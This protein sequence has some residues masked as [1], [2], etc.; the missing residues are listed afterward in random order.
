MVANFADDPYLAILRELVNEGVPKGDRTK[1][2]MRE[3]FGSPQM[4]FDL[5]TGRFPLLTTKKMFLKGIIHELLWFLKGDTNIKYL[6][7]HGVHIWDAWSGPRGNLGPV[8]GAQWRRWEHIS[9]EP[10]RHFVPPEFSTTFGKVAGVGVEG[11]GRKANPELY[12]TWAG[13]LYRCYDEKRPEYA[14]YGAQGVHVHERWHNFCNFVEDA[15]KLEGWLLKKTFWDKYS[16]DKDRK[17]SNRYGPD[18]CVWASVEEQRINT[19]RAQAVRCLTPEGDSHITMNLAGFCQDMGL[20]RS[21][22]TK[23]LKHSRGSHKGWHFEV[24]TPQNQELAP[25]VRLVDQIAELISLIQH[26][27]E[28]RRQVVSAWNPVEVPLQALPPCH[29]LWQTAVSPL[30]FERRVVWAKSLGFT[31]PQARYANREEKDRTLTAL[32]DHEG[33]PTHEL[34]LKLYQ[35]SADWFLGVPF[36]IA[37]YALLTMMIA[38]VCGLAP[39]KFIHTFGSAHLYENHIEQAKTQLARTPFEAPRMKIRGEGSSLEIDGFKFEDFEL[40]DYEHHP[41]ISAPIAV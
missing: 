19:S 35:R 33:Y 27:P 14:Y 38:K 3:L 37:S 20:D 11:G 25:R 26:K 34:H 15:V 13:M 30:S 9:W 21:T 17:N 28:S 6:Q 40:L 16:L 2:G 4:V 5:N 8:Y 41:K 7:D 32:L 36:N 31:E 39:G 1:T 22:V 24:V 29:T 23:V 18:T 10:A 12:S